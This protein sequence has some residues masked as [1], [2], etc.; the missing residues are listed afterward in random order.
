MTCGEIYV[1]LRTRTVGGLKKREKRSKMVTSFLLKYRQECLSRVHICQRSCGRSSFITHFTFSSSRREVHV[2][3]DEKGM[4]Q[5]IAGLM[6]RAESGFTVSKDSG[7]FDEEEEADTARVEERLL[8]FYSKQLD[9]PQPPHNNKR[10][11]T[12]KEA[13]HGP[14]PIHKPHAYP[15]RDT[16]SRLPSSPT[17]W[18]QR[19]VSVL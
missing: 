10:R 12:W 18:P 15:C 9:Q 6:L 17:K 19:P 2:M 13:G 8:A 14:L 4:P 3:S 11:P 16:H 5:A 1:D 7:S